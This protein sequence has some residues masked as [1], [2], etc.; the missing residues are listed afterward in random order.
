MPGFVIPNVL[1]IGYPLVP[2]I[3]V[4]ALGY[5]LAEVYEWTPDRRRRFLVMAG[6]AAVVAFI[7]LRAVNGYG[8]T[9]PWS[10]QRT[11]VLTVASFL[12]LRKYRRPCS[13]C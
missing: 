13:F 12:N 8:N 5:A 3:G 1:F 4:M 2:W 10:E 11:P 7:V 6:A 9:F